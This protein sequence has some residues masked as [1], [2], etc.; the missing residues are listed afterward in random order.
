MSVSTVLSSSLSTPVVKE[1]GANT[2]RR[3]ASDCEALSNWDAQAQLKELPYRALINLSG[4][5]SLSAVGLTKAI[6]S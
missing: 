1:S 3:Q 5:Q 2:Q 6:F 4:I